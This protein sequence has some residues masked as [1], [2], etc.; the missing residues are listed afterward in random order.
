METMEEALD[1]RREA[2]ARKKRRG[3]GHQR[4]RRNL[5]RRVRKNAVAYGRW[6][7]LRGGTMREAAR[8][9]T[10]SG[11]TLLEWEREWADER[12]RAEA[13]GRKLER[14]RPDDRRWVIGLLVLLGPS[15]GVRPLRRC[16]SRV[17]RGEIVDLQARWR[18]VYAKLNRVL[19]HRLTWTRAGSVWAVDHTRTPCLVDGD[20]S[21]ALSVR[22]LSSGNTLGLIPQDETAA[23]VN[24]ALGRL[25]S[26]HGEPLV[27]KADNGSAFIAEKTQSFLR[28]H[29]VHLLLSPPMTAR[30]NGSVESGHRHLKAK[31]AHVAWLCG[32]PD[33]WTREDLEAARVLENALSI[34]RGHGSRSADDV[35]RD[36]VPIGADE[37]DAF[38]RS[39]L[40]EE[41]LELESRGIGPG[42][43]PGRAQ[44]AEVKRTAISR[45]LVALGYLLVRRRSI[46]LP[47]NSK[48]RAGIS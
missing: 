1:A 33:D 23:A 19:V 3:A 27:L 37:R 36:R 20:W 24:E 8:V 12:L 30:Y 6:S 42:E 7:V 16:L 47:F 31:A 13:R 35:W 32:R 25:I 10:V 48:L 28:G 43:D 39:V 29:G 9:L 38:S 26:E 14:L 5:E 17:A 15:V 11:R 2:P 21:A 4:Q 46:P 44:L 41:K 34:P 22:D 40:A 18:R 45:A